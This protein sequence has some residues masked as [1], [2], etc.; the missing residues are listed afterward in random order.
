MRAHI[1][2][3]FELEKSGTTIRRELLAGLTTFITMSYIIAVNPA[4]MR[5]A[6]I[7]EGPSMVATVI[8][9]ATGT[10]IM[11]LYANRPFAI[12]PYMGENAFIAFT[13]VRALGYPWETALGAVFLAG[14]MFT[15]L[16]IGRVRQWMVEAIPPTLSHS[17]AA[18][19]GLFLAFIGLT[20]SGIVTAGIPGAPVKV[21]NL[22]TASPLIAIAGFTLIAVLVVRKVPGAI[23]IGILASAAIAFATGAAKSPAAWIGIPPNPVSIMMKV[24]LHGA[25]SV[26]FLGV[27]L[28]IF[29][30]AL[31][32]TMGSL[33][34]VSAR[35]GFLDDQGRLP[36]IERPMLAD[37]IATMIAALAGTTTAG[38]YIESAAGV[39]VGGRTGLTAVTTAA[40]FAASIFFAP[41]AAAIPPAAC[42]PALILVG[43]M[44]VSPVARINFADYTESIPAFAVIALMSFTYNIGVGIAAGLALYPALKFAA[45]RR[46][47]VR[48]GLWILGGLSL[49]FFLFYPYR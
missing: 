11:G 4:I 22:A 44:M 28:S 14:V 18:G 29:V 30:M 15:I 10:L 46:H 20:E 3:F 49:M 31:V 17:F 37:A 1:E 45:G 26:G 47:E 23:L 25:L 39:E 16:T 34:G 48:A 6:G 24:D 42:A 19:I 13:V 27:L 2:R 38:A 35:A 12:A 21:G 32:D 8:T 36:Q 7:P 43:A 5:A 33:I 9:A 40:L 41:L